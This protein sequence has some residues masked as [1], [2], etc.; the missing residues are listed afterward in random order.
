MRSLLAVFLTLSAGFLHAA[1]HKPSALKPRA[2]PAPRAEAPP[3]C[4]GFSDCYNTASER[5][6]QG[7]CREAVGLYGRAIELKPDHPWAWYS[8]S[9]LKQALG[10]A[11]GAKADFE[12][13]L[14]RRSNAPDFDK[15]E[16]ETPRARYGPGWACAG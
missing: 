9:V 6:H 11:A 12:Q 5:A 3:R 2:K 16:R 13:A 7:R 4:A 1:V 10:D 14:K 8:R 15:T